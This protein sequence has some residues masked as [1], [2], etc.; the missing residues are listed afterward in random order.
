M[1]AVAGAAFFTP[2]ATVLAVFEFSLDPPQAASAIEA[3]ASSAS[4]LD[5]VL[6]ELILR[7]YNSSLREILRLSLPHTRITENLQAQR[8]SRKHLRHKG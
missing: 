7:I 6:I 5:R 1:L 3:T 8:Q 2:R 4:L